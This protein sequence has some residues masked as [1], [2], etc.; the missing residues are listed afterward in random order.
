MVQDDFLFGRPRLETAGGR[1]FKSLRRVGRISVES[2][3]IC[4]LLYFHCI[5][6]TQSLTCYVTLCVHGGH[7][8][9]LREVGR[10]CNI[11][12]FPALAKEAEIT[13]ESKIYNGFIYQMLEFPYERLSD[14]LSLFCFSRDKYHDDKFAQ[15]KQKL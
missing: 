9:I 6:L 10:N 3:N 4:Y 7:L 1:N 8:V 15:T 11:F 14:H 13:A 5:G 12:V 2:C